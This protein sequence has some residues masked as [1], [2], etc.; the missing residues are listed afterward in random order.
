[1]HYEGTFPN[2]DV[3]DKNFNRKN[4]FSFRIGL[5]EVIKGWDKGVENMR[6]G[7]QR[8]LHVPAAMAYGKKGAGPIGPNQDLVFQIELLGVSGR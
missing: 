5:G 6:V 7:G 4:P 8:E 3:F 2:G 1:M